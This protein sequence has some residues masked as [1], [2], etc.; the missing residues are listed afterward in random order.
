MVLKWDCRY[1]L[2]HERL[3]AE[4]KIFLGLIVGFQESALVM[5]QKENRYAY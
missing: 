1:E 2:G 5:A 3:D 4:H